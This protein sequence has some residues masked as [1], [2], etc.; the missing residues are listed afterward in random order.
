[1]GYKFVHSSTGGDKG[2]A[3]MENTWHSLSVSGSNLR[4]SSVISTSIKVKALL[5]EASVHIVTTGNLWLCRSCWLRFSE[6]VQK[7]HCSKEG[8]EE[9]GGWCEDNEQN[10][11][12]NPFT[13]Q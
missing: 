4:F 7:Y 3:A 8:S 12:L 13:N 5:C 1:M 2:V 10:Q 6:E 9:G 11:M